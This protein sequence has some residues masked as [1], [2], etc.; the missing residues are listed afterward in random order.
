MN[1]NQ[2]CT[3]ERIALAAPG[4]DWPFYFGL[5]L[6]GGLYVFLIVAMLV[7]DALF[8]SPGHFLRALGSP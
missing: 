8:T 1:S 2:P 6:L 3:P 7:A 5:S 4:P